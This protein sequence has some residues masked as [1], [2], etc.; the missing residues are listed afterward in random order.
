MTYLQNIGLQLSLGK[1]RKQ[2]PTAATLKH[3]AAIISGNG[4]SGSFGPTASSRKQ[5]NA[6]GII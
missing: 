2:Y 6:K 5:M 4:I 1:A 3:W